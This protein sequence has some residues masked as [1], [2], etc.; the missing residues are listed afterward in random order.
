MA[1]VLAL[2]AL[3]AIAA[4]AALAADP[5]P[6]DFKNAAKYCKAVRDSKG[7]EAFQTAYGTNKNKKNAFGK[8][9]SQ[10]AKAA[11]AEQDEDDAEEAEDRKAAAEECDAER[12]ETQETRKAFE[13]K[14]GTN[15]NKRNAFGK[16]VSQ[17]AR[18][19]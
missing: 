11:R 17:K 9:V 19:D 6:A 3:V 14:Y 8:C 5:V 13:D 1:R 12:G 10:K 2:M 16:C 15:G 18:E 4:P 7:V